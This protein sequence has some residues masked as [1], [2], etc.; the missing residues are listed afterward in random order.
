MPFLEHGEDAK[1]YYFRCRQDRVSYDSNI[2]VVGTANLGSTSN[3]KLA[4]LPFTD[5]TARFIKDVNFVN[6]HEDLLEFTR[7]FAQ[8]PGDYSITE[9]STVYVFGHVTN[10]DQD[11]PDYKFRGGNY[12][13]PVRNLYQYDLLTN[14]TA[15]K[16]FYP[17]GASGSVAG[18]VRDYVGDLGENDTTPSVSA[19]FS[20]TE[21][22]AETSRIS[23][24][25]GDI[26]QMVTPY[27]K[28]NIIYT[29]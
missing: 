12:N 1:I 2:P 27:Y 17:V 22:V 28:P 25:M 24:W 15:I 6:I 20:S 21:R 3:A 9:D 18:I 10:S 16:K 5:A 23:H 4:E 11:A 7:I 19:Y 13:L 14:L 29:A 26:Y 8:I